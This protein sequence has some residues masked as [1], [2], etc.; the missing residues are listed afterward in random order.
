M[1][2]F[3]WVNSVLLFLIVIEFLNANELRIYEAINHDSNESCQF[4][5]EKEY[6]QEKSQFIGNCING[7]IEGNATIIH[8]NKDQYSGLFKGGYYH[9]YGRFSW[10]EDSYIE[11]V[12]TKNYLMGFGKDYNE[13]ILSVGDFYKNIFTGYGTYFLDTN[14][15]FLVE[16]SKE[17][18]LQATVL[19]NNTYELDINITEQIYF[20]R[21]S[22]FIREQYLP[23]HPLL[24]HN[25]STLSQVLAKVKT[26]KSLEEAVS[27]AKMALEL[28]IKIFDENS[29]EV[30]IEYNNLSLILSDLGRA[31]EAIFYAEKGLA[32]DEL[33]YLDN[34]PN[35][36]LIYSNMALFYRD[37]NEL[38]KAKKYILKALEIRKNITDNYSTELAVDLNTLS[39]I[40]Q[41]LGDLE[42]A[43]IYALKS[44]KINQDLL[45]ENHAYVIKSYSNLSMIYL[46]LH[47]LKEAKEYADKFLTLAEKN[48]KNNKYDLSAVYSNVSLVYKRL[49]DLVNS[50]KYAVKSMCIAEKIMLKNHPSLATV[51]AHLSLIYEKQSKLQKAIEYAK[52]ALVIRK[53]NHNSMG[54]MISYRDLSF[55]YTENKQYDK[56]FSTYFKSFILFL[57]SRDSL[58]QLNNRAKKKY[59]NNTN[60]HIYN[61]LDMSLL[62]KKDVVR[63][64]F[65]AWIQYKGELSDIENHIMI[66]KDEVDSYNVQLK[67]ENKVKSDVEH[68]RKVKRQYSEVFLGTIF[69]LDPLKDNSLLNI[70]LEKEQLEESLSMQVSEYNLSSISKDLNVSLLN[71]YVE[72]NEIYID[73]ARTD[74]NYYIFTLNSRGEVHYQVLESNVS[75]I[76]RLIKD[77]RNNIIQFG[78]VEYDS[79]LVKIDKENQLK[80]IDIKSKKLSSQLYKLLLDKPIK[81]FETYKK[82][83]ISPDGLLNF[84][85]FEALLTDK[86]KYLIESVDIQYISSAKELLKISSSKEKPLKKIDIVVFSNPNFDANLTIVSEKSSKI[87]SIDDLIQGVDPLEHSEDGVIIK[88]IFEK[89]KKDVKITSFS[90][91]DASKENLFRVKKPTIL[92]ISTH[93]KYSKKNKITINESLVKSALT[94]AGHNI[95]ADDDFSSIV[96]AL[97][98]STLNL[99][100]TD[101]VFFSSCESGLGDILSSEGAYGLSRAAKLA[102]A[103]RVISTIWEVSDE[104]SAI[105]T[106]SFYSNIEKGKGYVDALKESKIEMIEKGYKPFYWAGFIESG[107]N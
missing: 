40:Y 47:Q 92:H 99:Y 13:G 48:F 76:D 28:K 20:L 3:K 66:L 16:K 50:E 72:E 6:L 100:H 55:M 36:A 44:L 67:E 94:F 88:E 43:E 82:L 87:K 86:N 27:Y 22:L 54:L 96:T 80:L 104:K 103:K 62:V 38:I 15:S 59:L 45:G 41:D 57:K 107:M 91:K 32:I 85:P 2:I 24:A 51:Y 39:L 12:F 102:G 5:E 34:N 77:Y 105:I 83:I 71:N 25:Y 4:Y 63:E 64:V 8:H 98:F 93:S 84:L 23:N 18:L 81:D 29:S 49:G 35:L 73:F 52:K 56:A 89:R 70:Q 106:K 90:G 33:L 31:K 14:K 9:G 74:R 101:L 42:K 58:S 95:N 11:G 7:F 10:R 37:V 68:L 78:K 26:R 61:L 97:D 69:S 53:T 46:D 17:E 19:E 79:S 65:D 1:P 21:K 60:I 75:S 30:S